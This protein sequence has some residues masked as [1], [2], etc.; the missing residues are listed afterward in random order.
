MYSKN[1][2][3][4]IDYFTLRGVHGYK[5]I[6]INFTGPATVIVAENGTGKTTLLSALNAFLSR[7]FHRLASI[8]FSR[9]E[10]RF[11]SGQTIS[12]ERD[13]IITG[14]S[15]ISD[16]LRFTARD[17]QAS[18][19][20]LLDF[21]LNVYS[22]ESFNRYRHLRIVHQLYLKTPGD[23]DGTKRRLDELHFMYRKSLSNESNAALKIIKAHLNNVDIVF[24]PTYRRIERPMLRTSNRES[25][26]RT[27]ASP[28]DGGRDKR[29]YAY[30]GMAFGLGDI[31]ARLTELSEEIERTSNFG[32]RRW[33]TRILADS[34]KGKSARPTNGPTN[35][36]HVQDLSRFLGR[37]G[38]VENNLGEIFENIE[39]LYESNVIYTDEFEFLRYFLTG[40]SNVINQTKVLEQRI[41]HF[42]AVCNS[43]LTMSSDEKRLVFDPQNLK[44]YVS[45]PWAGGEVPL[46]E[47][48][49]GEKQIISLMAKSYLY[50]REKF[51]LI[52]EPELS[53]SID[54]QRKVLPDLLNSGSIT[55]LLAITHS[56]FIF[57]NELDKF[58]NGL[59]ISPTIGARHG[60]Y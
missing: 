19:D 26:S 36:P 16:L 42:V 27:G 54:W 51:V 29:D 41:E 46:D 33:S 48:S 9:L 47:L 34:L 53:L 44:V 7:R 57:E 23:A 12:L 2:P 30:E 22:P 11:K 60:Y 20:E 1:Q 18:E 14:A 40:L 58:T 15:E 17:A 52:D 5:D 59:R 6:S 32:Y 8:S 10:C 4:I 24:L 35:L 37:I 25:S 39:N 55:Q 3:P 31:E 56:P 28:W 38:Q 21:I 43:Y 13:S 50:D 45:N 49:S